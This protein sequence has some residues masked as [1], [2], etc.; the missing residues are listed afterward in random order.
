MYRVTLK[1]FDDD[2][3][4]PATIFTLCDIPNNEGYGCSDKSYTKLMSKFLQIIATKVITNNTKF[5]MTDFD[6]VFIKF[7]LVSSQK[8]RSLKLK[9]NP[10]PPKLSNHSWKPVNATRKR[11]GNKL[12]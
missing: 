11:K 6:D 4:Q 12:I 5:E 7:E 3:Y 1:P 9:M 8:K 10:M 2:L